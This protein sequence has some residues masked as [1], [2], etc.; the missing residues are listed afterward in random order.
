MELYWLCKS[1]HVSSVK[2]LYIYA[3]MSYYEFIDDIWDVDYTKFRVT[4]LKCQWVDKNTG[5]IV[6]NNGFTLVN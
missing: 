5:K 2:I 6:D 1:L 4:M 3:D